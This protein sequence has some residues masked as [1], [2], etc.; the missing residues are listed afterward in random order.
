MSYLG[1]FLIDLL[2][3][4][5]LSAGFMAYFILADHKKA[6]VNFGSTW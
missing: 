2:D 1:M 5:K 6:F 3:C 4:Y